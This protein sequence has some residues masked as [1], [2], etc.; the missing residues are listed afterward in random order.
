[1]TVLYLNRKRLSHLRIQDSLDTLAACLVFSEAEYKRGEDLEKVFSF[2]IVL[3]HQG[4]E[5]PSL[6]KASRNILTLLSV[7]AGG[8]QGER[9]HFSVTVHNCPWMCY[10]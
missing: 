8:R 6:K 1:M 4:E 5:N 3:W 9:R 10:S 2:C 7:P